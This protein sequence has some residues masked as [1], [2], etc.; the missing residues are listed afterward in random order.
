MPLLD[1][2][3]NELGLTGTKQGC[4]HEG[5][6]GACTILLDGR[7]IRSCLTPLGSVEGRNVLTIEGL[8][9]EGHLHPLQSTFIEVGAVQCGF[10]TPGMLLSA[11]ALLDREPKPDHTQI[12]EAL[13]GNLCR[14]TG[15]IRIIRAIEL[16]AARMR[17]E[18]H[19][20]FTLTPGPSLLGGSALRT[21][22]LEKVTGKTKYVEDMKIPGMLHIEVVRSPYH[23]AR[24]QSLDVSRALQMPGVRRVLTSVDIPNIN[25]FPDYSEEEP[26]LTPV[27]DT[28]RMRGAPIA[29][30]VAESADQA[31]AALE[32]V[33][34]D[35]EP[36]PYTFEMDDALEPS[37]PNIAGVGNELSRFS[38]KH[39]D[40]AAAFAASDQIVA[41]VF[42]TAYLEHAALERETL[43]GTMD[44]AGRITVIGGTHQPHNQQR[45][46][47]QML[48]LPENRLRVIVPPIGGSFGGKQDPWPFMAVGLAT[49]HLRQAVSLVYSRAESFESSPKRHPYRVHCK[50]GA[51]RA[52]KLTGLHLRVD[53]N[54]GGYDGG[55]HFIPNYALTAAGGAYRWQAVDGMARSVYT[56]GPKSGQF[57]GFGSTQSTFAL[58]CA[59]DELIEKSGDDPVEFRLRNCLGPMEDTFLGYPLADT[60]GYSQVLKAIRPHYRVF[61]QEAEDFNVAHVGGNLRRGIGLAGMWYRF[62]KEGSLKIEA[63][64]ELAADGHFVVYCSAPDYGQGTNTTMSQIAADAFGVNRKR[65][66]IVNADTARVPNSDIQGASRAT[67][68]VGGAVQRAANILKQSVLGVTAELLDVPAKNLMVKNDWVV[69]QDNGNCAV[70]LVDVAREFDRIG[71]SRRVVGYFDLSPAFPQEKRPEYLPLFVTGVQLADVI[72]DME[73]GVVQVLRVYAAHDV[74][75]VV[76]PLDASGQVEGAIVMGLGAALQEEYLPGLTTG[77]SHYNLP[78]I[79]ST[80]EIKVILVEVPSRLGPYGVKGL[81]EVA[82]LPATPAIINAVSRAIGK[83][84]RSIP[85]TPERVLTLMQESKE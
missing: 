40:M 3:R 4:D 46:M 39:G 9:E 27:G 37:A 32:A 71:K 56:N 65:V 66:E 49:Y 64:A 23:H 35:I 53:C 13:E 57:R 10:C 69:V 73:T 20:D 77:L 42:E 16:A 34:M 25:G 48:G 50:V 33:D 7:P 15:Y 2:L 79:R 63:H 75:R 8:A 1:V 70:P 12:V 85:A 18:T 11:K 22:S 31:H 62:G 55:G 59:L 24:L 52:G 60:L 44:E 80:P 41:A 78:T 45:R 61:L 84:L 54:T 5:E 58:E 68:F 26:V 47:A 67:F 82:M 19:E 17:G 6:C 28:L 36:L 72:V 38:I 14:C 43:L 76:N 29:L 83:R 74:G 21:D 51:T 81:G 30:V